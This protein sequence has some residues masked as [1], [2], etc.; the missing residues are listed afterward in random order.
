VTVVASAA[1]PGGEG[2]AATQVTVAVTVR[3]G[4]RVVAADA[5]KV[6]AMFEATGGL[7]DWDGAARLT[8]TV[9]ASGTDVSGKMTFVVTPGDGTANRAFLRIRR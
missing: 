3:D 2:T 9:T 6:A 7:G 8:P 5:E 1:L 4:E